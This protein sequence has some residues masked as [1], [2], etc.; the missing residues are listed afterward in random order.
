VA[1]NV[2][3]AVAKLSKAFGGC[4]VVT[5]QHARMLVEAGLKERAV[6]RVIHRT[7]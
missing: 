7:T 2:L 5:D 4:P 3:D 1:A 6:A